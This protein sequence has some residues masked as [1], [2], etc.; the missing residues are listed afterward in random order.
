LSPS[1]LLAT[2]MEA[3]EIAST[4]MR[5]TSPG[6]LTAKGDRDVV[7]DVD[8]AIERRLR[9]HL[10][11]R[12]PEIGFLGEEDGVAPW[13]DANL[14]WVLDPVDG[15]VNFVRNLPM[16][17]V[18]LALLD[19]GRPVL[20]VIDLPFLGARYHAIEDGGAYLGDRRLRLGPGR[21]LVEA[22]V[23]LGDFA[24]GASSEALNQVRVEVA[25]QLANRA[26][27]VRMLGSAA[28]DLAWLAEARVDATIT[29]ANKPWDMAAGVIVAREAGAHV[30]DDEGAPHNA[31][32]RV[33][34]AAA[35]PLIDEIVQLVGDAARRFPRTR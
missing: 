14:V 31:G 10:H 20:G 1:D 12:T 5:G 6:T 25:R 35:P 33:T 29:L 16:C 28:I 24:V 11:E 26:L 34:L 2:A 32:S 15:T 18:S 13:G 23:A 4:F 22:I 19:R 27:R 30:V 3:V 7:S 8:L 17:A 21:P 9:E